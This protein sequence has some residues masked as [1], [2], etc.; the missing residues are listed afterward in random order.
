MYW[1]D[2]K[3]KDLDMLQLKVMAEQ[4]VVQHK[5]GNHIYLLFGNVA[6]TLAP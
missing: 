6:L 1:N 5:K 2:I 4:S 3:V